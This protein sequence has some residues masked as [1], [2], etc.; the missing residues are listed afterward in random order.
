M[1]AYKD[2]FA[3]HGYKLSPEDLV[4]IDRVYLI[5]SQG[6]PSIT[7][8]FASPGSPAGIPVTYTQHMTSTDANKVNWSFLGTQEAYQYVREMQRKNLIIPLVGDFTGPKTIRQVGQ[9]LKQHNALVGA[10]YISNVEYYLSG[11]PLRNFQGNVATLPIDDSSMFIRWVPRPSI[12]NVPWYNESMGP[13]ITMAASMSELVTRYRAGTAPPSWEATL[14]ESKDSE[15]VVRQVP[16]PKL[17][18]VS[19]RV[20]GTARPG[21]FLRVELVEMPLGSGLIFTA[22]VAAD[23][24]FEIRNV[25]PKTYQPIVLSSCR[26][27]NYSTGVG[28][29]A[30]VMVG[31][32]D[33]VNLQLTARP[34]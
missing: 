5:F 14:R 33:V 15:I 4:T 21:E 9:Y 18:R 10:F 26:G 32:K 6:G 24:S 7:A 22:E 23:G 28:T 30:A 31:D 25:Q 20:T 17:R 29:G 13:V 12:P 16:D 19:G 8:E 1:Q 2:V 27:C 11:Q 3:K 34:R